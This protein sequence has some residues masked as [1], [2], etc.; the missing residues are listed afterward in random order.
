MRAMILAAGRGE[1]MR[2][3]TLATPKPLL[4]VA[5]R[6]LIEYH[7]ERLAQAGIREIVINTSWLGEQIRDALGDGGRLG[8]SLSFTIEAERL[9]SGG[10]IFN[11]LPLLGP[12]PFLL[13]N[14]DVW[15][16]I[17]FAS[18]AL[19]RRDDLAM[20]VMVDNPD[21]HPRGDFVLSD[22]GRMSAEGANRLTYSGVAVLSPRLFEGCAPGVFP[23][24]P[25]LKSAMQQGLAGGYH[26]RGQWLDVGTPER[27]AAA[28]QLASQRLVGPAPDTTTAVGPALVKAAIT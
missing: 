14:G 27:L 9:D 5:G 12:E 24:A 3:L 4:P 28:A 6:P 26:H 1:R 17:G 22:G 21:H 15:T 19:H 25:L 10:G 18:L 13:V 16:D 7:L 11:A 23:L 20:L 2:E 8:L